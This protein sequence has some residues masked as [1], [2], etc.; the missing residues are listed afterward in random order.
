MNMNTSMDV[1]ANGRACKMNAILQVIMMMVTLQLHLQ[2]AVAFAPVSTAALMQRCHHK[3]HQ[4]PQRLAQLASSVIEAPATVESSEV[5]RVDCMPEPLPETLKNDYYFLRHGQSTANVA[6]IISSARSLAYSTK[7]GLTGLGYEQ[8]MSSANPLLEMMRSNR[9]ES[10]TDI[11]FVTSP[12]A[13]AKQTAEA[14][15]GEMRRL[16]ES[17]DTTELEYTIQEEIEY[18][19][20]LMERYFGRLDGE[21]LYT[22]AYVWPMDRV[23]VTHTAFDVESVAAVCTRF[24]E[25]VMSMEAEKEDAI[26]VMASHADVCQISQLYAANVENVGE[27]SSYRFAN[28][29]VRKMALTDELLPEPSPLEA[30]KR[31][32][33]LYTEMVAAADAVEENE[34]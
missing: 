4:Q 23:D 28:G 27:F 19:D 34:E 32:T 26:I 18:D 11:V 15:Q 2:P 13:R 12:F 29:E 22:Y 33:V 1:N 9:K 31:G 30:P 10:R 14:C 20:R 17:S 21:A 24:R 5:L 7:H 6:G 8:G 3:Q 16:L 25:F